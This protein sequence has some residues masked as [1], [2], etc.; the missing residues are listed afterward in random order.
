MMSLPGIG[1]LGWVGAGILAA[2]VLAPTM[3]GAQL[4]V[5]DLDDE[6]V[7]P[8]KAP[9]DT[10]AIVL[11]FVSTDCPISNR[12]APALARLYERFQPQ[13]VRFWLVY[14]NPMDPPEAVRRHLTEY[15][16]PLPA[17]RDP[18]QD[19]VKMA[20]A[21]ITP[22]AAVYDRER[23]LLYR[24]RIDDRYIQLGLERPAATQHDLA[25]AL[26]DVLAGKPVRQA[27]APA[28]GCFIADFAP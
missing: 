16:L 23:R 26:S 28:V 10:K 12:Y 20:G 4:R 18:R 21:T 15:R 2:S 24:G 14:P 6:L 11:V 1:R 5:R 13:G 25:D 8:F 9:R 7:D 3:H 17:L 27:A 22:E 19:L